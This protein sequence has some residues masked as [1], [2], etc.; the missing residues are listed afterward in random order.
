MSASERLKAKKKGNLGK[1]ENKVR[2]VL[3][4]CCYVIGSVQEEEQAQKETLNALTGYAD[5][6][7]TTGEYSIQIITY[8]S[9]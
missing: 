6:L 7:L 9:F 4:N 5:Q 8:H 2:C 3:H 1:Q